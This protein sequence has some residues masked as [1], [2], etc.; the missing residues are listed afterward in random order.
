MITWI[1]FPST[2]EVIFRTIAIF[3]STFIMIR[4]R[5]TKQLSQMSLFDALLV[6]ALGSALGDVMVY[7]ESEV[8]LLRAIIAIGTLLLLVYVL[9]FIIARS[10][11]KVAKLVHG[12]AVTLVQ[13]GKLVKE[14]LLKVNISEV[15]LRSKMS[16][17]FVKYYSQVRVLKLEPNGEIS[18]ERKSRRNEAKGK[19]VQAPK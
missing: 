8:S 16:E 5:G 1:G 13:D 7:P 10:P 14:N 18:I 2:V 3:V 19:V 17:N 9:Q 12:E 15:Q 6:I 11:K 4:L